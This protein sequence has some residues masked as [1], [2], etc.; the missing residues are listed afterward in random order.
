MHHLRATLSLL[1][2]TVNLA[3]WIFPVLLL[4]LL[5][6]LL[7]VAAIRR[8]LRGG[9]EALAGFAIRL[10]SLIWRKVSG[11]RTAWTGDAVPVVQDNCVVIANHQSWADVLLLQ[12]LLLDHS[13]PLKWLAKRELLYVPVIGLICWAYGYPLLRR[14]SEAA[15]RDN[16]ALRARD[17]AEIRAACADLLDNPGTLMNFPEGTRRTAQKVRQR[18]SDYQHLLNP[19][20]GGLYTLLEVVQP[21]CAGV[22]DVTIR[23]PSAMP[24]LWAF[25]GGCMP[26]VEI[27]C[28]FISRDALPIH[29]G[30]EAAR[31]AALQDWLKVRW[32][33]KDRYLADSD[34]PSSL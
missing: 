25:L 5:N 20:A 24:S 21:R 12:D 34:Q 15:L 7:P 14:H 30:D 10:D 18:G 19:R 31:R 2:L 23:Y 17:R 22:L 27:H 9:M 8:G 28:K 26:S 3:F 16:P 4:A 29:A 6:A 11:V 1:L 13:P 33:E 32:Q